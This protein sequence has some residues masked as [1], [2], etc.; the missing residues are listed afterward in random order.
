MEWLAAVIRDPTAGGGCDG[1]AR[2]ASNRTDRRAGGSQRNVGLFG[3]GARAPVLRLNKCIRFGP[4]SGDPG[5][6]SPEP[7][8]NS[9]ST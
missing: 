2:L 3:L 8:E 5:S 9:S 7:L 4:I 1:D 6:P